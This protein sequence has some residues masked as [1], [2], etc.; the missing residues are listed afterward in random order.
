MH[1]LRIDLSPRFIERRFGSSGSSAAVACGLATSALL[2][3]SSKAGS[4]P[5]PFGA[6]RSGNG[7]SMRGCHFSPPPRVWT[8]TAS[9]L[10][11]LSSRR[12]AQA[13]ITPPRPFHRPSTIAA[14]S[15]P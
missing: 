8:K 15:E 3:M 10:I 9:D 2:T 4:L 12:V 14:F 13:G 1:A 5:A 6:A 7:G 11:V